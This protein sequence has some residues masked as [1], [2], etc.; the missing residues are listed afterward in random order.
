MFEAIPELL[1]I[2][3][4]LQVRQYLA[5]SKKLGSS[6]EI[7]IFKSSLSSETFRNFY[8]NPV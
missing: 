6:I 4:E 2:F 8:F 3:R 1:P 7:S 5:L